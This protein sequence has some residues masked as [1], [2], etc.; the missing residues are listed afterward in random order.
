MCVCFFSLSPSD[1][2]S[3]NSSL[4]RDQITLPDGAI[5]PAGAEFRKIWSVQNTGSRSWP[6]TKLVLVNGPVKV[7]GSKADVL[8][9]GSASVGETVEVV[10]E[11]KAPEGEGRYRNYWRLS[12]VEEGLF[13]D[14]LWL[15]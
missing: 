5:V 9:I 4:S 13:G 10:C 15:E 8:E 14:R 6:A 11:L 7:L 2:Q 12:G 1:P 3:I